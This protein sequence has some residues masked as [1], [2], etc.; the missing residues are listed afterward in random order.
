MK[1]RITVVTLLAILSLGATALA[2]P[3]Q[4]TL[5]VEKGRLKI[6]HLP[7]APS[8]TSSTNPGV[9]EATSDPKRNRMFFVA[10]EIG[11]ATYTFRESDDKDAKRLE[12]KIRVVEPTDG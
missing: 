6:L 10:Q 4:R 1:R 2:S 8:V 3:D 11:E 5:T 9:I 12:V 7:F